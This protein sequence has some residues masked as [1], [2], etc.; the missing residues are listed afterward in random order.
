MS[1]LYAAHQQGQKAAGVDIDAEKAATKSAVDAKLF[2]TFAS[3]H[4]GITFA[5]N[6]AIT[7]LR[8]D[9]VRRAWPA[10]PV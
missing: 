8:V 10:P 7:V 4:W 3:K 6:A 9:Q 1:L 2:D 5:A